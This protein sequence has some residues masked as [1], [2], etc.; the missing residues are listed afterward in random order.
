MQFSVE[1]KIEEFEGVF[2]WHR[3]LRIQC[4]HCSSSDCS[5][6]VGSVPGP[7]TSTCHR[8]DQK[9]KKNKKQKTKRSLELDLNFNPIL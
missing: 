6:G 5:Y 2:L 8:H 9:N 3:G 1:I 7:E 4:Y